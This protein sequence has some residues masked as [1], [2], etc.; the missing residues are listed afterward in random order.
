MTWGLGTG[1]IAAGLEIG[2]QEL[3]RSS[4]DRNDLESWV[5][6]PGLG[7]RACVRL[8]QVSPTLTDDLLSSLRYIIHVLSLPVTLPLLT[9]IV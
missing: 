3:K 4:N 1:H 7:P 6:S 5:W 2:R 8:D 9:V